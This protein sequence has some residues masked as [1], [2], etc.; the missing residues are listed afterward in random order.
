[1]IGDGDSVMLRRFRLENDVAAFLIYAVISV[2]LAE[3]L[4]E[5]RTAQV[6]WQFHEEARTSSRTRCRRKR[7]GFS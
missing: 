1:M 3:Q 4:D 5:F 7:A 6:T 2:I